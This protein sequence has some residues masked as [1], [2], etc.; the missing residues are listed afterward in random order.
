[1]LL[2]RSRLEIGFTGGLGLGVLLPK[3]NVTLLGGERHDEFHLAGYGVH[4]VLGLN[5]TF[6]KF[7]FAQSEFRGG[8]LNMPDVRTTRYVQDVASQHFFFSQINVVFGGRF[9]LGLRRDQN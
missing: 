9:N 8:F 3:T 4:G 2:Q 5:L 1:M 7:L 6:F